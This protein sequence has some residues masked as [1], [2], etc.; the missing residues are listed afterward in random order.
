MLA[1][2]ELERQRSDRLAGQAREALFG[3]TYYSPALLW[4]EREIEPQ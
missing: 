4:A 2:S 3:E 1:A